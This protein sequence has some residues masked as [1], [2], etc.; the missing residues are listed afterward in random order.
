[1]AEHKK[2]HRIGS[3]LP[4]CIGN[5]F[6]GLERLKKELGLDRNRRRVMRKLRDRGPGE[7]TS[8]MKDPE[9]GL[10]S[11]YRDPNFR[12]KL[13]KDAYAWSHHSQGKSMPR[14]SEN[15]FPSLEHLIL[16]KSVPDGEPTDGSLEQIARVF[17]EWPDLAQQLAENV[18]WASLVAGAWGQVRKRLD[19]WDTLDD[20]KREQIVLTVF[21][22]ATI[23]D[24]DRILRAA[25][26]AVPKMEDEFTEILSSNDTSEIPGDRREKDVL[27]RWNELCGLATNTFNEAAGPLPKVDVLTK[28]TDIVRQLQEIGP[29]V[30]ERLA[31]DTFESLTAPVREILAGLDGDPIFVWLD[32]E[33][34]AEILE[35]WNPLR[36]SLSN[37]QAGNDV[38][39]LYADA[40]IAVETAR[41]LANHIS[42]AQR[43][44]DALCKAKPPNAAQWDDWEEKCDELEEELLSL[45]REQRQAR[46]NLRNALSP[47]QDYLVSEQRKSLEDHASEEVPRHE[48]EPAEEA[49]LSLLSRLGGHGAAEAP[50]EE[51]VTVGSMDQSS[52]N[53]QRSF[54]DDKPEDENNG[55]NRSISDEERGQ[56]PVGG[57]DMGPSPERE[58]EE[59]AEHEAGDS[60]DQLL[61]PAKTRIIEALSETPPRLAYSF[62]IARLLD[63]VAPM[64]GLPPA[65]LFEAAMLS[66][67]LVLPHGEVADELRRVLEQFPDTDRFSTGPD[68]DLYV[69]LALCGTLRPAL[70]VPEAGAAAFLSVLKP[71]ERL[72]NVYCLASAVAE[73]SRKL[74]G[75]RI[76][77]TVLRCVDSEAAWEAERDELVAEAKRWEAHAQHKTIKY[78]PATKVWQTWVKVDGFVNRL[79]QLIT[80]ARSPDMISLQK[81]KDEFE[82]QQSFEALVKR[83]DRVEIGRRKGDDIQ[84]GAL[85]QLRVLALEVVELARRYQLINDSRPAQL[86]FLTRTLRE[87]RACVERL[88]PP[89]LTEL[90]E[91]TAG[92]RSLFSAVANT[93][94]QALVRF[95]QFVNVED[96]IL[97][98][99]PQP[100]ELLASG[101]FAF[102]RVIIDE[103]GAPTGDARS[104]L[105]SIVSPDEAT[106]LPSAVA[107]RLEAGDLSTASRIIKWAAWEGSGD[108][109]ELQIQLR[110]KRTNLT[111]EL[112]RQI[113]ETSTRIA[114]AALGGHI[115]DSERS[116][117]DAEIVDLE[118]RLAA[119]EV[120]RFDVERAKVE[121]ISETID[122]SLR[123]KKRDVEASFAEISLSVDDRDRQRFEQLIEAGDLV[124]ANELIDRMRRNEPAAWQQ[125]S[126]NHREWFREF[127]PE[128]ARAIDQALVEVDGRR[129]LEQ[130]RS[131]N[132][133]AG[134]ALN[135]I[136]GAQRQSAREMLEAWFK[137]KRAGRLGNGAEEDITTLLSS[138]GFIVRKVTV[139]RSERNFGEARVETDPIQ[140]RE[141]CPIPGFGSL[142]DGRYRLVFLWGRPTEEDILQHAD[143]LPGRAATIVVYL[144]RLTEARRDAFARMAR[145]RS[146]TLLILDELLLVFLCGQRGSRMPVL[147]GC[148]IPFTFVQPYVTTAGV[149]PPEMFFGREKEMREITDPEGASF[150]YGGRQL[151]KTALLRSVERMS[152]RPQQGRYSVWIDLKDERIGYDR[153]AGEIWLAIWRA[154]RRISAIPQ[155]IK[156]VKE[157]NPNIRGRVDTFV[158]YLKEHFKRPTGNTLLLLLDEADKF[159]ERDGRERKGTATGYSELS[160]LKGLMDAT[161]RSVKVVFAGLHNVLR[162]VQAAN[163]PLGHLGTPIEVGPLLEHGGWREAEALVREPLLASGYRFS[164]E[165]LVTRILAQTNYYPSLIQLYGAALIKG[166]CAERVK[167]SP[168]Y[169]INE[170][171]LEETYQNTS[172]REVIRSR[173]HLTLQLDPRYE[174]IAY[175]IAYECV[176][177]GGF[178][179][180]GLAFR[181]I[182]DVARGWWAEGFNDIEPH[183]D[184]FRSLLDEMVGLGV[185]RSVGED[186]DL[187]TLRNPNV[188]LLMGTSDEIEDNLLR[189][190]QMPPEFEREV[191]RAL[192]PQA[193]DGPSR[194]PMTFQQEDLLRSERN[195]VSLVCGLEASGLGDVLRYL[196]ARGSSD[197][198]FELR[199]LNSGRDFEAAIE[200]H[201]GQRSASTT[202]CVTP[203][204]LPW[205]EEWVQTALRRVARLKAKDKFM[206]IV[207]MAEPGQLWQL[208]SEGKLAERSELQWVSLRPW[209]SAFLRQWMVDVGFTDSPSARRE[210]LEGTG[211]WRLFLERLHGL[212]QETGNLEESLDKLARD[213]DAGDASQQRSWFGLENPEIFNALKWLAVGEATWSDLQGLTAELGIDD[214]S[215]RRSLRWGELLHV[216]SRTGRDAWQ[217]DSVIARILR[218][219]GD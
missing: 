8:T 99:E 210:I 54:Q 171:I 132:E 216:V 17:D 14:E 96:V 92:E 65:T 198:V 135:N 26:R 120:Q 41:V 6:E 109:D 155:E 108:A 178:L 70:L 33:A 145:A 133:F 71:S 205:S 45:R 153:D 89:A 83:T 218:R 51:A 193:P 82:H 39:Q 123:A 75:V 29:S 114:K 166:M 43:R 158:E 140:T 95:Q 204:D 170:S 105:E 13:W 208:L 22:V 164:D 162:T 138:L 179:G 4:C 57:S 20:E 130:L 150:I 1:M 186:N 49:D 183:T 76:D 38:Q 147:F 217:M 202:I 182:D 201:E 11:D 165:N 139:S 174:V 212:H 7:P 144:G 189:D 44:L 62:Q 3:G 27:V 111:R 131:G 214:H 209:R 97:H 25:I 18:P 94:K 192:D 151:G 197:T 42:E 10:L 21:A 134:V 190:R 175:S 66:E 156:G 15:L 107:D 5:G 63:G 81:I 148:A 143:A 87:L 77:S 124:T 163:H 2:E 90:D 117:Y 88:S 80:G 119:S 58:T 121:T 199:D 104:I 172:L 98:K 176:R 56:K 53:D 16:L 23:V 127:Y 129:I 34:R 102:P 125:Q 177:H 173:F 59:T 137:L 74:Q 159:L 68:R 141:R 219:A 115:E 195:G 72:A 116:R 52:G 206:Q 200:Q 112:R 9:R 194:S 152:H 126:G 35:S 181:R 73:Q 161:E 93:A 203:S 136:P 154:L 110:E 46:K 180:T 103:A 106:S 211:G 19:E 36:D 168:L 64:S 47:S 128:S 101:L 185:L 191:F 142:A 188:L 79:I 160:R 60:A 28:I 169:E 86:D 118:R 122:E 30:R 149:V 50:A 31:R 207:F 213:L 24:D 55:E 37:E 187:Y 67:Y 196:R 91:I 146:R 85:N 113:A 84:A 100:S 12:R 167:G 78:Q 69:L 48:P 184:R 157:P 215:L 32:D 40:R 61:H